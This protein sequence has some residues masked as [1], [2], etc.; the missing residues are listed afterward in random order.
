LIREIIIGNRCTSSGGAS[1]SAYLF[2][3]D[4]YFANAWMFDWAYVWFILV[5]VSLLI[6]L[7]SH[8]SKM[9]ALL[10]TCVVPFLVI[11]IRS[12]VYYLNPPKLFGYLTLDE[13]ICSATE[14]AYPLYMIVFLLD[15]IVLAVM[16]YQIIIVK[17][18]NKKILII[19]SVNAVISIILILILGGLFGLAGSY[20]SC[21][22]ADISAL[23]S[24]FYLADVRRSHQ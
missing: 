8:I 14:A 16:A 18:S 1:L 23:V 17:C 21:I 3:S 10:V 11:G 4:Y 24:S 5:V 15:V 2:V 12:L 9:G 20:I 13:N 19:C 6:V 7:R 22:I